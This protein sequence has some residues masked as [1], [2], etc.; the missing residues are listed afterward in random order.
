MPNQAC[1]LGGEL[2]NVGAGDRQP[3]GLAVPG[4]DAG[5]RHAEHDDQQDDR[6]PTIADLVAAEPAQRQAAGESD[7]PPDAFGLVATR[8][9][10]DRRRC[11]HRVA[12]AIGVADRAQSRRILG[13]RTAYSTSAS[14]LNRIT[15]RTTKTIHGINCGKSPFSKA[16]RKKSP[17]PLYSKIRSV[18]IRPPMI[19]PMSMAATVTIGI[20]ALRR[21]WRT[22]IAPLADPLGSR[23]AQ[24]VGVLD[25][26]QR[27]PHVAAVHGDGLDRHDGDRQDQCLT[28]RTG[29]KPLWP[30]G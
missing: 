17:I 1:E 6:A 10:A 11:R 14:R 20:S 9:P 18:M 8:A 24:V 29:S 23:G 15:P 2:M 30:G 21:A 7:S 5:K 13:S 16:V 3:L 25:L 19:A 28:R 27:G 12:W 26:E 4:R 22:M